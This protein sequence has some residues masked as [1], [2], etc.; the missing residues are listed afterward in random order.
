MMRWMTRWMWIAI[1]VALA[2]VLG[3]ERKPEDPGP[4]CAAVTDH[5]YEV[6]RKAYPGHGD[7]M[8]GNRKADIAGCE[9]RKLTAKQR[10]CMLEAQSPDAVAQCS[11]EKPG[12]KKQQA[13]PPPPAA[14]AAPASPPASPASP[15]APAS[16]PAA[17]APPAPPAPT[18]Q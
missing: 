10:R 8:M 4:S 13:A 11:R 16:P 5:V 12:E 3:C 7:M 9:A 1:T 17:P 2:L 14:P 15:A 6:T 18:P